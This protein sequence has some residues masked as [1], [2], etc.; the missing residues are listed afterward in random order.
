[1]PFVADAPDLMKIRTALQHLS[2]RIVRVHILHGRKTAPCGEKKN[3]Y[4]KR[5][6]RKLTFP[7]AR[8]IVEQD[9]QPK[10]QTYAQ[11]AAIHIL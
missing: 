9:N 2:V 1:M 7:E 4:K 11:A 5:I 10:G 3:S 6:T 8:K